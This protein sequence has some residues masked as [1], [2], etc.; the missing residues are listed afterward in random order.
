M[1]FELIEICLT[2]LNVLAI[3]VGLVSEPIDED[4]ELSK[5]SKT[6]L[7]LINFLLSKMSAK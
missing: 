1:V 6:T 5:S 7:S 2:L 3:F 4:I